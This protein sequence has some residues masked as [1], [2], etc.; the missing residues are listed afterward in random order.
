MFDVIYTLP[1][2]EPAARVSLLYPTVNIQTLEVAIAVGAYDS[3]GN[4]CE[5]IAI[6]YK[7]D[8]MRDISTE[9]QER[10]VTAYFKNRDAREIP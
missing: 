5:T 7:L 9:E 8:Q 6:P 10:V 1:N 4:L 2:G 3:A